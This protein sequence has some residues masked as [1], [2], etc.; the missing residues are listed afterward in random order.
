[1]DSEQ[2]HT[3]TQWSH[4]SEIAPLM[5]RF[6]ADGLRSIDIFTDQLSPAVYDDPDLIAAISAIARRSK[7]SQ[8]RV[9]VRN[10]APLYGCGRP[11]LNLIQRLPSRG[12]IRAYSEGAKDRHLGFFCVDRKHLVYFSNEPEWKGF[13]KYNAKAESIHI[14]NEFEH[15]WLYGSQ[16][17]PNLRALTL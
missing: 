15:L 3:P 10:P 4:P 7:Q 13:A 11:L 12:Q 14:L 6:A 16:E 8:V 9:L 2:E 5:T 1:M 17:D